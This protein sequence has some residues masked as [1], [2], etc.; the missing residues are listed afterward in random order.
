MSEAD[1]SKEKKS[2]PMEMFRGMRDAYL[3]AMAKTMQEAVKTEAY[4][5]TSGAILDNYLTASGPVKEALDKS[6]LQALEQLSL[7]SRMDVLSLSERFTNVELRLDDMD[8]KLDGLIK[9][10]KG[11]M[12]T[13]AAS[14]A[15]Q[16][17]PA[18]KAATT[19]QTPARKKTKS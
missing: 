15:D 16:P 17:S 7:P 1:A 5:Q 9:L 6:M 10:L 11:S 19:K 3:G 12:G 18:A 13:T 2:D 8:A 4:A 14:K